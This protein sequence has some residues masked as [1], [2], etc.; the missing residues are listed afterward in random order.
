M[1]ISRQL[2]ATSAV[3]L[4]SDYYTSGVEKGYTLTYCGA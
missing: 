2:S 1:A 3:Q 4:Y